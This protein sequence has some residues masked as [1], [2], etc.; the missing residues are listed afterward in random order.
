[1]SNDYHAAF[2]IARPKGLSTFSDA[3]VSALTANQCLH[4]V[5]NLFTNRANC[6]KRLAFRVR[7]RPVDRLQTKDERTRIATTHSHE[8]GRHLCQ[9]GRQLLWFRRTQVNP[10]FVHR[11]HNFWVDMVGR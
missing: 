2:I 9:F 3:T 10:N 11:L 7:Q 1:M 6:F 4:S 5:V 8:H